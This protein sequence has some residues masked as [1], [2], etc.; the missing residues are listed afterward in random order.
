MVICCFVWVGC[1]VVVRQLR[2]GERVVGPRMKL[3]FLF[4][5]S[6]LEKFAALARFMR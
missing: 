4:I 1:R 2:Y 6:L 5:Y 3:C